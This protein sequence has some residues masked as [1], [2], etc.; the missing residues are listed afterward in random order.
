MVRLGIVVIVV[1]VLLIQ[2]T[3]IIS[4]GW[5]G[6]VLQFG[7]IERIVLE[8]GLYFKY[9]FI[10]DVIELNK[11]ILAAESHP[12]EY[13]TLD[14]KRLMVDTVARW[15]IDDPKRFYNKSDRSHVVL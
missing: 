3:F 7:K 4:E 9:P 10:Q 14:K 8:P 6:L 11:R 1:L 2:S 12:A 15:Q 5:Q 13:I